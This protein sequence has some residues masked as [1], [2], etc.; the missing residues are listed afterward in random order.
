MTQQM[1]VACLTRAS[2]DGA[3][4]RAAQRQSRTLGIDWAV[5]YLELWDDQRENRAAARNRALEQLALAERMG[6]VTFVTKAADYPRAMAEALAECGRR[7]I[8]P[9]LVIVGASGKND[10]TTRPPA[11]A[12]PPSRM[13]AASCATCRWWIPTRRRRHRCAGSNASRCAACRWPR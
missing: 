10:A 13:R 3:I 11:A 4:L 1:V 8:A 9:R 12:S 5:V 2:Q 6:A 7:D